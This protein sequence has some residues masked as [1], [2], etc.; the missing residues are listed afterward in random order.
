MRA[1]HDKMNGW[2]IAGQETDRLAAVA[3]GLASN[4]VHLSRRGL[5]ERDWRA[6][7]G[8]MVETRHD[9]RI[10]MSS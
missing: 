6:A 8:G 10:A 9:H 5:A 4:S 1:R 2:L 7:G 3:D